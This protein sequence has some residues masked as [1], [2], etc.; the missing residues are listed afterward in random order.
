MWRKHGPLAFDAKKVSENLDFI[1]SMFERVFHTTTVC[2][3]VQIPVVDI[4]ATA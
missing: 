2:T 3:A 4:E 1:E